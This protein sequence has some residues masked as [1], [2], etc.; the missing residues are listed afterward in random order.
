MRPR[1]DS[2][3]RGLDLEVY[4]EWIEDKRRLSDCYNDG[5]V[6]LAGKTRY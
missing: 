3:L 2:Q 5:R 4:I 1:N 6:F